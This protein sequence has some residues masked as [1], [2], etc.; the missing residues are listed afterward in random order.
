MNRCPIPICR[1]RPRMQ[2]EAKWMNVPGQWP[3]DHG[4]PADLR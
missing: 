3:G 4:F 1:R 2:M